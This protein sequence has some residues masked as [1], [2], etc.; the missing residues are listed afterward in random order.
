MLPAIYP[1]L[2]PPC[3]IS[4]TGEQQPQRG[5]APKPS[6]CPAKREATLGELS[7]I[8]LNLEAGCG[9]V[10][11]NISAWREA[12]RCGAGFQTC[13]VADFQIGRARCTPRMSHS[14]STRALL[15]PKKIYP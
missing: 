1:P 15:F 6:G 8:T 5:C 9:P 10:P 12:L 3:N 7:E 11:Q 14:P 4:L 2:P 13:C